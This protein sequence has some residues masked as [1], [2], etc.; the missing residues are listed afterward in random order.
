MF[1]GGD[2]EVRK[3][4]MAGSGFAEAKKSLLQTFF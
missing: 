3:E 4:S 1:Q 2:E